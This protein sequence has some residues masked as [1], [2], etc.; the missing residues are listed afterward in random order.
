[1]FLQSRVEPPLYSHQRTGKETPKKVQ[2]SVQGTAQSLGNSHSHNLGK[3]SSESHSWL[4]GMLGNVVVTVEVGVGSA[5][6]PGCH[7]HRESGEWLSAGA[8][9]LP[10]ARAQKAL[11]IDAAP[12]S[13]HVSSVPAT[14]NEKAGAV[15]PAWLGRQRRWE[16][17]KHIYKWQGNEDKQLKRGPVPATARAGFPLQLRINAK[18]LQGREAA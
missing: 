1:M 7:D 2:R 4:P 6:R 15:E 13:F 16:V 3:T 17:A 11:H 10:P 18:Q 12:T 9:G 5:Q 14:R 8:S